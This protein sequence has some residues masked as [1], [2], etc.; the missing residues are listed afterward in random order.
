MYVR[1]LMKNLTGSILFSRLGYFYTRMT[2]DLYPL[3]ITTPSYNWI[4][5]IFCLPD[6][7]YKANMIVAYS[8]HLMLHQFQSSA[9]KLRSFFCLS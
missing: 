2:L 4:K 1:L 9:S 3:A 6:F 8:I 7:G 5:T